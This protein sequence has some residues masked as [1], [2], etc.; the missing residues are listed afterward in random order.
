MIKIREAIRSDKEEILSFCANTFSWGDYIDQVWDHWFSSKDNGQ[1]FVVEDKERSGRR[2]GMSHVAICPER[3]LAWL[4]GVRVHPE[5]RR[6]K[7]ATELLDRMLAY[8]GRHGA[9]QASAIVSSENVPS[10][11]MMERNGFS[12]ISRWVYYSSTGQ[13]IGPQKT[14]A[15]FATE[16][17][18]DKIW[19]YLQ[20]SSIYRLSAGAYV[21]AWHW[22]PL[23]KKAL[24]TLVR[25]RNVAV[26]GDV[27]GI[28]VIS[29]KGY[30]K[31]TDVLQVVYLDS[32]SKESLQEL[33]SFAFN[34]Y[35]KGGYVRLHVV[36]HDSK[37]ITSM[38]VKSFQKEQDDSEHFLLY[39]KKFKQ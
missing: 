2:I 35:A 25:E 27:D 5:Y 29:A 34:L 10:Q 21:K 37:S 31:R 14:G 15:R 24:S 19:T 26:T 4:E 8:A 17:D 36:C 23:N 6:T 18:L 13:K 7:I 11:R 9:R 12:A 28:V 3:R 32:T 16:A 39:T 33:I 30:W 38:L 20:T 22:Y 1:L